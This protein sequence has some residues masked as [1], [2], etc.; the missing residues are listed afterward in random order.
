MQG[1]RIGVHRLAQPR[2]GLATGLGQEAQMQGSELLKMP[3][4]PEQVALPRAVVVD[5]GHRWGSWARLAHADASF[6]RLRP[7]DSVPN[8]TEEG[9]VLQRQLIADRSP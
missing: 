9:L 7:A 6:R 1:L 2:Q 4:V 3:H 8:M 5:E